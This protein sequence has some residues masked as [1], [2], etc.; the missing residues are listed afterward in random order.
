MPA[1]HR[2]VGRDTLAGRRDAGCA[3]DGPRRAPAGDPRLVGVRGDPVELGAV[4]VAHARC[5]KWERR[6]TRCGP[7]AQTVRRK[8]EGAGTAQERSDRRAVL[9]SPSGA[10]CC[11][12][13][14]G[15]SGVPRPYAQRRG[16]T[17]RVPVGTGAGD[18]VAREVGWYVAWWAERM[19][20]RGSRWRRGGGG[21]AAARTTVA[22]TL[23]QRGG[24]RRPA[25]VAC[26]TGVGAERVLSPVH[27]RSG[28]GPWRRRGKV[29]GGGALGARRCM[30]ACMLP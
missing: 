16:P 15:R 14:T 27:G 21:L 11:S 13:S 6:G 25:W 29:G 20:V 24:G 10:L 28:R 12:R 9:Q 4:D 5:A 3:P 17:V 23:W 2:R 22:I 1:A 30:L 7:L 19:A 18:E 26:L 8:W